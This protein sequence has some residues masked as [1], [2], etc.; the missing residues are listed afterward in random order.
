MGRDDAV[1]ADGGQQ[2]ADCGKPDEQ[3]RGVSARAART[4]S[5]RA[6]ATSEASHPA[7]PAWLALR[8]AGARAGRHRPPARHL[9][10]AHYGR[11]HGGRHRAQPRRHRR[12]RP[13]RS[14]RER[15]AV[16]TAAPSSPRTRPK[17]S[18]P[19]HA[20]SHTGRYLTERLA[21]LPSARFVLPP[22]AGPALLALRTVAGLDEVRG[23]G[24]G[25]L[26]G[27]RT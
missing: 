11:R 21:E 5:R 4:E 22:W 25:R 6:A 12:R 2:R 23:S 20:T 15:R 16:R 24:S 19:H 8:I 17:P 10:P 3:S 27:H 26:A 13:D 14:I 1:Q 9:R 18:S 7:T